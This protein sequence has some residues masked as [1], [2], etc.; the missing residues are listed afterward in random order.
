MLLILRV[1]G[2]IL[3]NYP[4]YFPPNFDSLFLQGREATFHGTYRLAFYVHILTA[5]IVLVIGLVLLS[6]TVLCRYRQLHRVLGRIQV[7]ILLLLV[8]PSSV[9]M[10]RN[11]FAG[12]VAGVSFLTLS[13]VTAGCAIVGLVEARRRR[14]DRHRR[15]MT[16][17]YILLCSA[18]VLRLVSGTAGLLGVVN[19]EMAYRLAAWASWLFPLAIGEC[20]LRTRNMGRFPL[21]GRALAS[22]GVDHAT[23]EDRV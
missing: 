4:D 18:V 15:W 14:I 3:A 9:V 1:L 23:D 7:A 2:T 6:E 10:S 8:L 17:T 5:P 20:W 19:P 22:P 12:W 21:P 13:L 16:R 11:A